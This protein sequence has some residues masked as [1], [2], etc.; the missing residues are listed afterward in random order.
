[1]QTYVAKVLELVEDRKL[2]KG[3]LD[4]VGK[5]SLGFVELEIFGSES[6]KGAG[7]LSVLDI[8]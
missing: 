6:S 1:M 5:E 8:V 3:F 2:E 7:T 4:Q